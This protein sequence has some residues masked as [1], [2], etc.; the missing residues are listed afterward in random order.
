MYNREETKNYQMV[1]TKR[2]WLDSY[3]TEPYGD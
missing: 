1:Y 2:Q 3:D